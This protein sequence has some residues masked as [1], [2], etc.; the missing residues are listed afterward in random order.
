MAYDEAVESVPDDVTEFR[1][2]PDA[3][4]AKAVGLARQIRDAKHFVVYTGAGVSTAADIPDYRGPKCV[5]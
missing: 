5:L 3:L 1:E 2:A 4:L